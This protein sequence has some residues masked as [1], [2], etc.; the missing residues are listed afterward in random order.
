VVVLFPEEPAFLVLVPLAPLLLPEVLEGVMPPLPPL[1]DWLMA[2]LFDVPAPEVPEPDVPLPALPDVPELPEPE[3]P[4]SDVLPLCVPLPVVPIPEVPVV[5]SARPRPL[6]SVA[7]MPPV[8]L[9]ESLRVV[10][11]EPVPNPEVSPLK[12]ELLLVLFISVLVRFPCVPRVLAFVLF[13]FCC[14]VFPIW[15]VLSR[16]VVVCACTPMAILHIKAKMISCFIK[17]FLIC[18]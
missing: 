13:F 15:L 17:K 7:D 3:V 18:S 1:V 12:P 14:F 4:I 11:P 10:L 8:P 6:V 9:L 2:P 16:L 5:V